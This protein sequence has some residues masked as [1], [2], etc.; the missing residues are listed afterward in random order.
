MGNNNLKMENLTEIEKYGNAI[1]ALAGILVGYA[2]E[3]LRE[4]S[5]H[6]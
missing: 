5:S 4:E 1:E 3:K 2:E 6:I